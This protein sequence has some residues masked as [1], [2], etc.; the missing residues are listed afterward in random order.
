LSFPPHT[1]HKLQPLDRS[2]WGTLKNIVNNASDAW[3]RS[4]PGRTM[5]DCDI[6][7]IASHSLP[8]ALTP[9]NIV[10]IFCGR[11]MVV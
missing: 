9:K 8:N 7:S 1:S 2:V 6:P 11:N 10:W 5:T 3:L 4:D